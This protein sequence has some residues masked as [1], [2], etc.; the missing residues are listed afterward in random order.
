MRELNIDTLVGDML[1]GVPSAYAT[2]VGYDEVAHHS[3]VESPDSLDVLSKMDHQ[4][5][6][7]ERALDEAPRPYHIVLLSDHGQSGGASF[8]HRYGITLEQF[9]QE[10]ATDKFSIEGAADV[11]EDWG[12][13]NVFLTEVVQ[14][15]RKAVSRPLSRALKGRTVEDGRVDLG[16]EGIKEQDQ[17]EEE[18][19]AEAL[20]SR[21]VVLGS[22]NLG[23]VYS[24]H[25]DERATLEEIEEI[26]PGML[27]GM[28]EHE[29]IGFVMVHSGEHGPV[30]IGA[31]G[32]HY[33]AQGR[34]E[35][36]DPLIGYGPRAAQHLLRTD[37]F[38]DAP[39]ILVV[40]SCV[41]DRNEVTTFEYQIG[42]H[43][44]LGGWQTQPFLLY[45]AELD[46]GVDQIVG[47]EGLHKV[48]KNW[49][50][51]A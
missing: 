43:G 4:L 34:I 12:Q 36:L 42:S 18:Y 9:V 6:R 28:V 45:P 39:D 48:L 21:L 46:T 1:A 29:G 2:F 27:E 30:A 10:L 40:S 22:G 3:G 26:V 50:P 7:L 47:A 24:S 32:R 49:V 16:P 11:H 13:V 37:G 44:G 33:L 15:D 38:P 25:R 41:P 17:Q 5:S 31:E 20:A 19:S 23:L 51:D 8:Q 14:H 35:G